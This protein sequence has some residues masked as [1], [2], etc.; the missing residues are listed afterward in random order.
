MSEQRQSAAD[1][2]IVV[3]KADG[4]PEGKGLNGLLVDWQRSEPR[5][6]VAKPRRQVLAELFTSMLVLSATF[7]FRPSVGTANYLYWKDGEWSLSLVSP[8]EWS[9]EKR[10]GFVGTCV[11]QPDMTWT[12]APSDRLADDTPVAAAVGRFYDA[13]AG[14]L[15]TDLTLDDILPFH[16]ARL[17]YY[18]RLY[19]SALS[20][21]VRASVTKANETAVSGREWLRQLPHRQGLLA[22]STSFAK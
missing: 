3:R 17:R 19:A 16:V 22:Q 21:S 13:F 12:I 7:R 6:V 5:S 14:S 9:T 1:Q 2:G 20:R 10:G 11:L 8:D 4:N 18:P 15:D